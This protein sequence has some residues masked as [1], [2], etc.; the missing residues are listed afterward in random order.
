MKFFELLQE[1]G[2]VMADVERRCGMKRKI[3]R[4][5]IL[6]NGYISSRWRQS[7][8]LQRYSAVCN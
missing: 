8:K 3:Y 7:E 2:L 1:E 4:G 5:G 6:P